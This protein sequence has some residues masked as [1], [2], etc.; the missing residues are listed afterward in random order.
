MKFTI[1]ISAT[2]QL[3]SGEIYFLNEF[4]F[5]NTLRNEG[6]VIVIEFWS[7][8][9]SYNQFR[10]LHKLDNCSVYR[11]DIDKNEHIKD[12]YYKDKPAIYVFKDGAVAHVHESEVIEDEVIHDIQKV[13]DKLIE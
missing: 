2:T 3:K 13:I 11:V 6:E 1:S 7:A 4:E 10:Y 12:K 8:S 9:H 5:D